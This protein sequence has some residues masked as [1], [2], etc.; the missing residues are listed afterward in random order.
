MESKNIN[1]LSYLQ[2][3]LLTYLLYR[4]NE[5]RLHL[6]NNIDQKFA[7]MHSALEK[8]KELL[9]NKF[10]KTENKLIESTSKLQESLTKTKAILQKI[11]LTQIQSFETSEKVSKL[12]LKMVES[13]QK[14]SIAQPSSITIIESSSKPIV[15][16]IVVIIVFSSVFVWW[17]TPK[18][19]LITTTQLGKINLIVS[20]LLKYIPSSNS[21]SGQT[22][23]PQLGIRINT[24]IT[25]GITTHTVTD[26]LNQAT[27]TLEQYLSKV[28]PNPT[29]I[30][31]IPTVTD[32][33]VN[34]AGLFCGGGVV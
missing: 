12:I 9:I 28:L 20:E 21:A 17:Y 18:I 34:V 27:Y 30:I 3:S 25:N 7:I 15:I 1:W 32:T 16:G 2:L 13:H 6:L 23:I 29:T 24:D 8:N 10:E 33:G 5:Y 22:F 4:L 14:A 31:D 26:T 11:D 19:I